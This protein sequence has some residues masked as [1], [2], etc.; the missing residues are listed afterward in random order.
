[1]ISNKE[2]TFNQVVLFAPL[3]IIYVLYGAFQLSTYNIIYGVALI[4]LVILGI[5]FRV[6]LKKKSNYY[7]KI[8]T[9]A[10]SSRSKRSID[11]ISNIGTIQKMKSFDFMKKML[12]IETDNCFSKTKDCAVFNEIGFTGYKLII[13]LFLPVICLIY[14]L[15]P[16]S[17]I[18]KSDF[19]SFIAVIS[20]QLVHTAKNIASTLTEYIKYQAV[21]EK[22]NEIYCDNNYREDTFKE[23]FKTA[24]IIDAHHK[25]YNSDKQITTEVVIPEFILRRGDRVALYGESGQGKTTLLNILSGEIESDSVR[26]NGLKSDKRLECVFISQDTE[27]LDM[28][29]RDN[30]TLGDN[31]IMDD[32]I[33]KLI[34]ACGLEEWFNRQSQGLDTPLGERGVFVSTGQRQRL[35]LIRG[36][37]KKN[38]E[39]YLLDEPTSNV[40]DYT[41]KEM[42]KVIYEYLKDKTVVIVTHR[43]AIMSICTKAYKFTNGILGNEEIL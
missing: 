3:G 19:F 37:L 34:K 1:M 42:V 43:Q 41:E 39:V 26:L 20:V 17:V 31:S 6:A 40:D 23:F 36:L 12:T 15:Y 33:I 24:E 18:D 7:E 11:S 32:E 28:S 29:L 22:I 21:Y 9:D 2:K 5:I 13:Y 10:E 30:L 25:Y 38:G 35:N 27:M 16:D 4:I 14:Y 8:L